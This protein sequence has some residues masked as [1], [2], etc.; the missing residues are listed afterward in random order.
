MRASLRVPL[1][2]MF[3]F[4]CL[5][6]CESAEDKEDIGIAMPGKRDGQSSESANGFDWGNTDAAP[7]DVII[8]DVEVLELLEDGA[9]AISEDTGPEVPCDQDQDCSAPTAY[10]DA[11]NHVCV[12]CLFD[13]QCGVDRVC[14]MGRCVAAPCDPDE[15]KCVSDVLKVCNHAGTG[16]TVQD[17]APMMCADGACVGCEPGA[18]RCEGNNLE[19]CGE[20]GT[21]YNYAETC[22]GVCYEGGCHDCMPGK[23][24]CDGSWIVRCNETGDGYDQVEDCL[25]DESGNI[26]QLGQCVSLCLDNMKL[27]TNVGCDYWAADLD[28]VNEKDADNIQF[29]VVVSN[30]HE[31]IAAKIQITNH[32]SSVV[33]EGSVGAG[34]L[35]VFNLPP[36]NIEG[37]I[38]APLA[39]H[40]V[41]TIPIIAY[42]FNPLENAGVFSNDASMLIPEN[43][44]GSRYRVMTWSERRNSLRAYM[45]IVG[46]G[47]EPTTVTVRT[48]AKTLG[49]GGVPAMNA[50]DEQVF[51]LLPFEVLNIESDETMAELT[52]SEI[53]SDLPVAVFVGT[54]CSN[55]PDSTVCEAGKC[56]FQPGWNCQGPEDCPVTCCCDHLEEQLLPVSA[57][58]KSYI[59]PKSYDRGAEKDVWRLL[60]SKP[61]T[62]ITLSPA[63]TQVP[64]LQA[65]EF[66]QFQSGD[67]LYISANEPIL[68]GQFLASENAP[69]PDN[70]TCQTGFPFGNCKNDFLD[71][72]TKNTDCGNIKMPG[73]AG[74]GD[75]AFTFMIPAEQFREEY[76]FLVPDKYANDYASFVAVQGSVVTLDGAPLDEATAELV[77]NSGWVTYRMPL[78]DG[79]HRVSSEQTL[80]A[81]VYGYDSYVSYGYP[82]GANVVIINTDGI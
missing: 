4:A 35:R 62:H 72:C 19:I 73:D 59:A 5:L 36:Q 48:T 61:D 43:S 80:G 67:H 41:S 42:Q 28:Q 65:G 71:I 15:R 75:P 70:D 37:A 39:W 25:P 20:G 68:V 44:L 51:T 1:F 64:T 22:E 14:K 34:E 78:E 52:G 47:D 60:A 18:S 49:G 2:L 38:K 9:E 54:V 53:I 66:F 10:C 26:C 77:G 33:E 17:C 11:I 3:V 45:T 79:V 7:T 82:A 16:W 8:G 57:W 50:G 58:G 76:L 69:N 31:S 23:D 81:Y 13:M 32:D 30:V 6:Q 55:V 29:S 56:T 63:V 24:D 40:V 46:V 27:N 12:E 74:I 21:H